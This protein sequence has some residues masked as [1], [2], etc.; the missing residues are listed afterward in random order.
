MGKILSFDSKNIGD[1]VNETTYNMSLA[2]DV[3]NVLVLDQQ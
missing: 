3:S 2:T 1:G